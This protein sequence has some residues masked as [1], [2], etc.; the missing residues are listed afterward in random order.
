MEIFQSGTIIPTKDGGTAK[1]V[2]HLGEGAQGD[3]YVVEYNGEQKA[4]KWY[5]PEALK[6]MKNKEAFHNNLIRNA[7]KGSP[8]KA[9]LWPLM[10]TEEMDESFGYIMELRPEG[11]YELSDF[12]LA[13]VKFTTF[14]ASTEACMRIVSAFRILHNIGYCYQDMNDGNFFIN[15]KTG[16]VLICDN[17]NAAPNNMET[18]IAGTPRY[19][20]PEIVMGKSKPDTQTDRFSLSVVLFMLL[21][22]NHPFEGKK[23]MVACLTPANEKVLYGENAVFIYDETDDSNRPVKNVHRNVV[24]R[25]GYMPIYLKEMFLKAFSKEAIQDP[26]KRLRE[27]D[28][29]NVLVRFQSDIVRCPVCKSRGNSNEIFVIDA[30]DTKCDEC[31]NIFKVPH[32]LKLKDYSVTAAKSTRIYRCQID[33]CNAEDALD[34]I[35]VIVAKEDAPSLL[36]FQNTT[37]KIFMATTPSGKN[38]QV[39]P[40]EIIPLKTG[41][42]FEVENGKKIEI[43]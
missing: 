18:F 6:R 23:W 32:T 40:G 13:K 34:R 16:D 42:T 14:K 8:D 24:Q 29:L 3:V 25:W 5:K 30:A 11:Y 43:I 41:I 22:M 17:D 28:W 31:G 12:M 37:Q 15:P 1:V 19:M 2:K 7:D 36:G 27:L 26:S 33:F 4:M 10:V 21:F 9:F 39:K 20:A 38:K 35:G